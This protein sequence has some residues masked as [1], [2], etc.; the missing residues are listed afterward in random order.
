VSP[1]WGYDPAR[2]DGIE[3]EPD[4]RYYDD[5][6]QDGAAADAAYGEGA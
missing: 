3:P 2:D 6:E 4:D 5:N 1:R